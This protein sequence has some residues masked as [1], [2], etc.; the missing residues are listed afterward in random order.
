MAA[1]RRCTRS[2]QK[3]PCS[4][5]ALLQF[6]LGANFGPKKKREAIFETL[7]STWLHPVRE[8]KCMDKNEFGT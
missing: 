8:C 3:H 4:T 1:C 7:A 2:Y 6:H 5:A